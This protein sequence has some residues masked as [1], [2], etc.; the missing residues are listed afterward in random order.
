MVNKYTKQL[1][2]Q[3]FLYATIKLK[4]FREVFKKGNEKLFKDKL[5]CCRIISP[6]IE[7]STCF[8]DNR[9]GHRKLIKFLRDELYLKK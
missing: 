4:K 9:D 6:T 1:K 7:T 5:I 2:N 3:D 8:N